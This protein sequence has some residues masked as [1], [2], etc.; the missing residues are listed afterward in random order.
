MEVWIY[1][2]SYLLF[3]LTTVGWIGYAEAFRKAD[4][5][6]C[7]GIFACVLNGIWMFIF[8]LFN[9]LKLPGTGLLAE[10]TVVIAV[11]A[12]LIDIVPTLFKRQWWAVL[13]NFLRLGCVGGISYGLYQLLRMKG[14][15]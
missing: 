2:I 6:N 10:F 4:A 13:A 8:P 3:M 12:V 15:L 9:A 1:A 14:H 5:P 11:G 7:L